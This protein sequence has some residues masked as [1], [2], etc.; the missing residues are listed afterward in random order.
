[1]RQDCS[2]RLAVPEEKKSLWTLWRS[3]RKLS[4]VR[5]LGLAKGKIAT[6]MSK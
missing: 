1:M 3:W 2:C 6:L 4:G 5:S